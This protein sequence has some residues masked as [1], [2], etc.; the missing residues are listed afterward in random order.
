MCKRRELDELEKHMDRLRE[1]LWLEQIEGHLDAVAR[2]KEKIT[3]LRGKI[4]EEYDETMG[5]K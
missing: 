1:L 2:L 5:N 4:N 3:I